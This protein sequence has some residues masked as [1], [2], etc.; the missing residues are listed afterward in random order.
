MVSTALENGK[1]S[2]NER[3]DTL[4]LEF[5]RRL[6][7]CLANISHKGGLSMR[8]SREALG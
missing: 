3:N 8:M 2:E 6:W 5:E 4:Q 7:E 1:H